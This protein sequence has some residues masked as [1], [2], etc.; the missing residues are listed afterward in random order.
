MALQQDNGPDGPQGFDS[1]LPR[2]QTSEEVP[3]WLVIL[4]LV[5]GLTLFVALLRYAID[6]LGVVFLI[7]V[8]GFS[9]RALSDWLTEGESVSGWALAA[10]SGGLFGTLAVSL[11]LFGS[12]DRAAAVFERKLPEPVL[13]TV[14]WLEEHGWG[15]RVL[16]SGNGL[17]SPSPGRDSASASAASAPAPAGGGAGISAPRAAGTREA[18]PHMPAGATPARGAAS[19]PSQPGVAEA[20]TL[21]PGAKRRGASRAAGARDGPPS[22]AGSDGAETAAAT[23]APVDTELTLRSSQSSALVGTAVRLTA[24]VHAANGAGGPAGAVVFLRGDSPL[25]RVPVRPAGDGT[26]V[27]TLTTLA[28]PIGTHQLTAEFLGVTGFADCRS[29]VLVQVVRRH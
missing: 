6:L 26:S 17:S 3:R 16:L 7:I 14:E 21:G 24:T 8:V 15:Q 22:A 20:A 2:V 11:W 25:G 13:A 10:V 27:A 1:G 19:P 12:H 23:A 28:L 18:L 29:I 9:I 5:A 4:G